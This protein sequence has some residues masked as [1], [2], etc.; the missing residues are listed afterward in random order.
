MKRALGTCKTWLVGAALVA[1]FAPAAAAAGSTVT[2]RVSTFRS[3]KGV[4][5]C[6]LYARPDGFPGKPPFAAEES[7]AVSAKT[8]TCAFAGVAPGTYAVALFHDENG[9]GKLDKNFLGI[10]REGVGVSNNKIRSFGPVWE[11]A[12]FEVKG[13]V[14]LDVTLHY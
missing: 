3:V 10:P 7:V 13:D 11:D 9:D 6:R 14:A 4:L 5:R 2:V 12:K 8:M 1:S